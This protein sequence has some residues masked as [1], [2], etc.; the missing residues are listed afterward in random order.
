MLCEVRTEERLAAKVLRPFFVFALTLCTAH[1]S[2][3]RNKKSAQRT[4]FCSVELRADQRAVVPQIADQGV[5]L[6]ELELLL[7]NRFFQQRPQRPQAE[8]ALGAGQRAGALDGA[9]RMPSDQRK[10][11]GQDAHAFDAA[12][13]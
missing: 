7:L 3:K 10:Q 12:F 1:A 11:A 2:K 9:G 5:L 13:F 8:R 4:A 6:H